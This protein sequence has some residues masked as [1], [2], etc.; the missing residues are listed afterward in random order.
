MIGIATLDSPIGPLTVAARRDRVCVL[1]FGAADAAVRRSLGRW[2]PGEAIVDAADPAG[3]GT[4]LATYFAGKL[5]A[6]DDVPVEM[7]GTPFQVRV[8]EALRHV[9]PGTTVAYRDIARSID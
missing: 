7:N 6:L 5:R 8:W 9:P 1:H 3:V 2:Y 4:T